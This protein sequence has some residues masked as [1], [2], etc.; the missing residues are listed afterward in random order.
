MTK[1]KAEQVLADL[2]EVCKKHGVFLF[3]RSDFDIETGVI[4]IGDESSR[5]AAEAKETSENSFIYEA[6]EW[7]VEVVKPEGIA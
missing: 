5:Y 2:K 3:A 7:A 6:D 1:E 4:L